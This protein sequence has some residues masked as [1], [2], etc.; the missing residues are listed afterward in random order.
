[1]LSSS[2]TSAELM[3]LRRPNRSAF[4]YIITV[5]FGTL[6]PTSTT[7]VET[8]TWISP[9]ANR[10]MISFSAAFI[11]PCSISTV[12]PG[13]SFQEL[14]IVGDVFLPDLALSSPSGRSHTPDG[15]VR[16]DA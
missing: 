12:M 4:S 11:C 8:S 13:G 1:M 9:L 3:E 2:D 14:C 16:P 5:A 7:V 10:S 6:T 15:P